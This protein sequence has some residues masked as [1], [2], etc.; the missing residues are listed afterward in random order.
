MPVKRILIFVAAVLIF[1]AFFIW[2]GELNADSRV[3]SWQGL[4]L[5][6]L[7]TWAVADAL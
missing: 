1:L 6:G 7:G 4:T 2:V 5:L 3:L